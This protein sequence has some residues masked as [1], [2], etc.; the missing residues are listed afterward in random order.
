[1]E[2]IFGDLLFI[3]RIALIIWIMEE[4][5]MYADLSNVYNCVNKSNFLV[6]ALKATFITITKAS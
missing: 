3:F 5:H 6:I 4:D 2:H 1:M